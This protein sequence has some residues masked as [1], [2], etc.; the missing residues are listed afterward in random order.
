MESVERSFQEEQRLTGG[1]ARGRFWTLEANRLTSCT[2]HVG[3]RGGERR[4]KVGWGR[5][6]ESEVEPTF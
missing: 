6:V 4:G 1:K 2:G 5:V 3:K